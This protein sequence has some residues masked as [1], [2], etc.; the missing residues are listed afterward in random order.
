M[1]LQVIK[2]Y[3]IESKANRSAFRNKNAAYLVEKK[4]R[5]GVGIGANNQI[6]Q[7][8]EFLKQVLGNVINVSSASVDWNKAVV[9]YLNSII[10]IIPDSGYKLTLSYKYKD[11]KAQK[12]AES[13][14]EEINKNLEIDLATASSPVD[15][16]KVYQNYY[17]KLFNYYTDFLIKL[18]T[19][20][21]DKINYFIYCYCLVHNR[22]AN[23]EEDANVSANI[24]Y[25]LTDINVRKEREKSMFKLSNEAD[26]IYLNVIESEEA[27]DNM[28]LMYNEDI[29][30][31]RDIDSKAI[32]L[33]HHLQ[34]NPATFLKIYN[35]DDLEVKAFIEK[36]ILFGHLRRLPASSIITD[37]D[38]QIV[39]QDVSEAVSYF[40]DDKN[41]AF[42]SKLAN[43]LKS[44]K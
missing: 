27:L 23:R 38:N 14:L 33:K 37:T 16:R 9:N 10:I 28:L 39:G 43:A 32:S 1:S 19:E 21:D 41:S 26:K 30:I 15:E 35:D 8:D 2:E 24:Q 13:E 11:E 4:R 7:K 18:K 34:V 6:I 12:L 40:R 36:C 22:V 29:K 17:N 42:A 44:K 31:M 5:L 3:K 25:I 20:I